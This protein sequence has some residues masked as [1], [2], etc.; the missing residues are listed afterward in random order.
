[1]LEEIV[2]EQK[3]IQI[4]T[5]KRLQELH[6]V[7]LGGVPNCDKEDKSDSIMENTKSNLERTRF[8]H[9]LVINIQEAIQGGK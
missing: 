3:D 8:I 6:K 1:M 2:K 7:L 9:D 4:D 5:L